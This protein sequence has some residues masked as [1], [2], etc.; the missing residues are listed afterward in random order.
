MIRAACAA[1]AITLA[2]LLPGWPAFAQTD[3][4]A[5]ASAEESPSD[6]PVDAAKASDEADAKKA[7]ADEEADE[8]GDTEAADADTDDAGDEKDKEVDYHRRGVYI[9]LAGSWAVEKFQDSDDINT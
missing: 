5:H 4:D 8:A 3:E 2:L 9:G 6:E 7:D 1:L